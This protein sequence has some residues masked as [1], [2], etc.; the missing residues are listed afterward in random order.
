MCLA[1]LSSVNVPLFHPLPRHRSVGRDGRLGMRDW[2]HVHP[3]GHRTT[4]RPTRSHATPRTEP[5]ESYPIVA[6]RPK[7]RTETVSPQPRH[8]IKRGTRSQRGILLLFWE[9]IPSTLLYS[10]WTPAHRVTDRA[11]SPGI[12]RPSP[13]QPGPPGVSRR[14]STLNGEAFEQLSNRSFFYKFPFTSGKW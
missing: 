4:Q 8:S 6:R 10:L 3:C 13:A 14:V 5:C 11:T 12:H 7:S 9:R 2:K 1:S